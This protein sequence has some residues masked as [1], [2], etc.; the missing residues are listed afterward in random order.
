MRTS[1]KAWTCAVLAVFCGIARGQNLVDGFEQAADWKPIAAEG[2]EI[3]V[4]TVPGRDG[5][6]LRIDYNFKVGSGFCI[7]QRE[8]GLML[9]EGNFELAFDV[10]GEGPANDL[11]FKILDTGGDM[12][13]NAEKSDVWWLN[14]RGFEPRA[15]WATLRNVRRSIS[16]AWGP[17]GGK[18]GPR[19]ADKIEFAIAS[20]KGGKGTIYLDS[21][22]LR[23]IAAPPEPLPAPVVKASS[24]AIGS[25]E[26]PT[27]GS[28]GKAWRPA[29][30]DT[31]PSVTIDF[32][33]AREFSALTLWGDAI[34]AYSIELS[35]D[36][37]TFRQSRRFDGRAG[38]EQLAPLYDVQ[39]RFVRI[40]MDRDDTGELSLHSIAV[41]APEE[42]QDAAAVALRDATK[43]QRYWTVLGRPGDVREALIN[44]DGIVE[45]N[46]GGFSLAP[47]VVWGGQPIALETVSVELVDASLPMPVVK[48]KAGSVS[49]ET[50]A[51]VSMDEPPRL[52]VTYSVLA[53][54]QPASES[55]DADRSVRFV[56]DVLPRQVNPKWQFL[57]TPG[58]FAPVKSIAREGD[59]LRV[60]VV[61]HIVPIPAPRALSAA[62]FA[63]RTTPA[64]VIDRPWE[65]PI[66]AGATVTDDEG[67][68]SGAV[69]WSL[70]AA[71]Q[72]PF[73]FAICVPFDPAGVP[74]ADAPAPADQQAT[75]AAWH[76]LLDGATVTLPGNRKSVSDTVKSTLAH[77][78]INADGPSIQPGSRSYERSWI[79]DGALTS[80][81]LLNFGF[82][83]EA[84]AFID[85]Y[86]DHLIEIDERMLKAP[87]V[88]DTR[89]PDPVP[90]NDSHGQYIFAVYNAYMHTKDRSILD[91]HWLKI[92]RVAAYMDHL[93][94]S[95]MTAEFRP[96]G[97]KRTEPGK[98]AVNSE[99]FYGL[100][101]ESISHEGYSSKPMH[102]HWDNL[103]ALRGFECAAK[104]ADVLDAQYFV[105]GYSEAA[106]SMRMSLVNSVAVGNRNH[107]IDYMP[108]C[109][110][111]GDFDSTSTTM[112]VWPCD[113]T[114]V[115]G[116]S[117]PVWTT[118]ERYWTFFEERAKTGSFEAFTP[119]EL[120]HVGAYARMGKRD[121]AGATLDWFMGYR[122]PANWNQ[123]AEVVWHDPRAPKFIG[124]M[125]HTWC[126]SDFL[127][128][129]AA[130]MV[131]EKDDALE[132]FR[133]VP[134]SWMDSDPGVAFERIHTWY[135]EI[136]GT[137]R[138]YAKDPSPSLR[139][140]MQL[141]GTASP[142][143][144]LFIENPR[145]QPVK[146]C[147]VNG[148]IVQ[149]HDN[150]VNVRA[151]PA[152]LI[153]EYDD[154]STR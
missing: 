139:V 134:A 125:P 80:A 89:G 121:R 37:K 98:P 150:F 87:C 97:P 122:R 63:A 105:D 22:T 115:D 127:N 29:R 143:G 56:V 93:R 129:V 41:H 153:F 18:N 59:T 13:L 8:L 44:E 135:G 96:N 10:K 5:S 151:L 21:L 74:P 133:G 137:A 11:E 32:G 33:Y 50:R 145:N 39:S 85:W 148:Q 81:A 128:S 24:S 23:E 99:A 47:R 66:E 101:P 57:T 120:R 91:R 75:V 72:E 68:A 54:Q 52:W 17:T 116:L 2:V 51:W 55:P 70:D 43:E 124:D 61:E 114:M 26:A 25:A 3:Q 82:E 84:I 92:Q 132:V 40:A 62:S 27:L 12:S 109:V 64:V 88:V 106:E 15:E 46:S 1:S 79:R 95:R 60:N 110:E 28:A 38:T 154:G 130:M 123:W 131:Y 149:A 36:G 90:E 42:F 76:A 144:G 31:A 7:V 108:G 78:L 20:K 136:S 45:V 112:A 152:S 6:C 146:R 107:G 71:T 69:V 102:S 118:F 86:A 30:S 141:S 53:N 35:D 9:P 19:R 147:T 140:E 111:L 77:I 100:M 104:I 48:W 138:G 113:V 34:R 103:W 67:L 119:Y 117:D 126:G 94:S 73:R 14:R 49:G 83:K 65:R 142:K 4:S 16:Y 58:G